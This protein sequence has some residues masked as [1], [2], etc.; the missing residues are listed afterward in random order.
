MST[1][2]HAQCIKKRLGRIDENRSSKVVLGSKLLGK[3]WR[4]QSNGNQLNTV[5]IGDNGC[6]RFLSRFAVSRSSSSSSSRI[7]ICTGQRTV[8]RNAFTTRHQGS[9]SGSG[10]GRSRICALC[11]GG[12]RKRSGS[13]RRRR[14]RRSSGRK[15][16][17]VLRHECL[18]ERLG[19]GSCRDL[20][21]LS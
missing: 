11:C 18:S 8:R 4:A 13:G 5:N 21:F 19:Q 17:S 7:C 2:M 6:R 16:L 14:G 9:R 10:S 1:P 15:R 12:R 20:A 3:P